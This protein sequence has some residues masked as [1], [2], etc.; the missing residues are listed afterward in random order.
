[1]NA[2]ELIRCGNSQFNA[3]AEFWSTDATGFKHNMTDSL[4]YHLN[5]V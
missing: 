4:G 2:S 5:F 3:V 1:M